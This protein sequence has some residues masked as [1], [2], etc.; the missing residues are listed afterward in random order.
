M[1]TNH[2]FSFSQFFLEKKHERNFR[3]KPK[4]KSTKVP[5]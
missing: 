3:E 2:P 5:M 4:Q 1:H